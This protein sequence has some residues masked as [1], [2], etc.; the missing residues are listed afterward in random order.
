MVIYSH[1]SVR[2][3][4]RKKK[5][6]T[7]TNSTDLIPHRIN[8][9]LPL[10]YMTCGHWSRK[11][12]FCYCSHQH[13][14]NCCIVPC[15]EQRGTH[16]LHSWCHDSHATKFNRA[17][18]SF[19]RLNKQLF[20][21]SCANNVIAA[22]FAIERNP[23]RRCFKDSPREQ[24]AP[25]AALPQ[26]AKTLPAPSHTSPSPRRLPAC[27]LPQP[28]ASTQ[29]PPFRAPLRAS[30]FTMGVA[31][32]APYRSR[33]AMAAPNQPRLPAVPRRASRPSP[34]P[35]C[36]GRPP[37]TDVRHVAS[38]AW[39]H[40]PFVACFLTAVH[41][42]SS[43]GFSW[44]VL[45]YSSAFF[46]CQPLPIPLALLIWSLSETLLN[47]HVDMVSGRDGCTRWS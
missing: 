3:G 5:Q 36:C 19:Q 34:P 12:H 38:R 27:R 28:S 32:G 1:Y 10:L 21:P 31:E 30:D 16:P 40:V 9:H 46:C 15:G 20:I 23:K 7:K 8:V 39:S 11:P 35:P 45:Y 17:T 42:L 43:W 24:R 6:K 41:L 22:N 18:L 37:W 26:T 25:T 29:W 33:G 14:A 2:R 4:K 44:R 13:I 47:A